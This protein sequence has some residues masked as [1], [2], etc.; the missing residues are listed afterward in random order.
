MTIVYEIMISPIED[1][2]EIVRDTEMQTCEGSN[3]QSIIYYCNQW[4]LTYLREHW[5]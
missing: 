2:V 4:K 3:K 5:L 1:L